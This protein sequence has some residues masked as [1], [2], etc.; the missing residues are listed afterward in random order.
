MKLNNDILN[1]MIPAYKAEKYIKN[2]LD[3][4]Y[5]QTWL[6]N[7]ENKITVTVCVDGCLDTLNELKKIKDNYSDLKI[8][9]CKE[10][11]GTYITL[12]TILSTI[13]SGNCIVFGADDKMNPDM[14]ETI[15]KTKL[16]GVVRSDGVLVVPRKIIEEFG[17]FQSWRVAGDTELIDRMQRKGYNIYRYPQLF[18]R[19]QHNGQMTKSAKYGHDSDIRKEHIKTI[20]TD[21]PKYHEPEINSY[22]EIKPKQ[23]SFNIATYPPRR[24]YLK[25]VIEDVYD[26]VDIIRVCLNEYKSIPK[27]LKKDKIKAV[28]PKKDLRDSGK[29]LWSK[30]NRDEYYFT[31]DDDLLYSIEYFKKHIKILKKYGGKIA[32]TSHGRILKENA[33][34]L[35]DIEK[36][37]PCLKSS[38]KDY[39]VTIGG[40]GVMAIDLSEITV[41]VPSCAGACDIGASIVL[42]GIIA[43]KHDK[44]ELEYILPKDEPDLWSENDTKLHAKLLKKF[45]EHPKKQFKIIEEDVPVYLINRIVDNNKLNNFQG[46]NLKTR[47]KVTIHRPLDSCKKIDDIF[48][49]EKLKKNIP[50]KPRFIAQTSNRIAF[51]DILKDSGTTTLIFE[52]DVCFEPNAKEILAKAIEEFPENFGVCYLGCYIRH[53]YGKSEIYSDNLI[54]LPRSDIHRIWGC[55]A[56]IFSKNVI[57]ILS[58]PYTAGK[59]T[60]IMDQEVTTKILNDFDYFVVNPMIAFQTD[61]GKSMSGTFNYKDMKERSVRVLTD[62]CNL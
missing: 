2:C 61:L 53:L 14:I 7:T 12:N 39:I 13:D 30:E 31:G 59:D 26:K 62:S 17:G 48:E 5:N 10:N 41:D 15:M 35:K 42:N 21:R 3:S 47:F 40:T 37:I 19:G 8:L 4:V 11:K 25:R 57:D 36:Y 1:V 51:S 44:N 33:T 28:I 52:D 60:R 6:N 38:D 27:W 32:V 23:I 29:F 56:V 18:Y 9:F 20:Q 50:N 55:H 34:E 46:E 22:I 49:S 54:K 16:G 24:Q 58:E 45:W 43:R